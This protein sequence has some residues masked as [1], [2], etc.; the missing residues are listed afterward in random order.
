MIFSRIP[1]RRLRHAFA[2]VAAIAGLTAC[3]GGTSQYETFT[4]GR[5][6]AFGDETSAIN[7]DGTKY[8]INAVT[9]VA[10][11]DGS[12]TNTLSCSAQPNWVQSVA[13][14]YGYVFAECNP[15]GID[16]PKALMLA[17][18][19]AKVADVKVQV[20]AQLSNG[21]FRSDDLATVLAGANDIIELY[22]Q[23]PGRPEADLAAELGARGAQ[24][25]QQVNRLVGLGPRVIISTVPDM[26]LTPYALQQRS[27]FLDTDRSALLTRLTAAFNDQLGANVVLD[28]RYVGLV[29]ADLRTQA[30]VRSPGSFGLGN[31]TDG[32]C[33]ETDPPPLC[34]NST[35]VDGAAFNTWLWAND[36]LLAYTGQQQLAALA[37]DRA[38]RNPF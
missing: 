3:G 26:G 35:L 10:N 28:G 27:E 37:V 9:T 7:E 13:S 6:L 30:M 12:S 34:S 19:G 31:V 16:N 36:L 23:Y 25:A 32:A 21:G 38:R 33:L 2:C 8:S 5:V 1:G 24:L 18:A 17:A 15:N 14:Y 29:Q 22:Q 4:A 11:G 20:D